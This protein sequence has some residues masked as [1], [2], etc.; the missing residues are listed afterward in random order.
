MHF[1]SMMVMYEG[2]I[3]N[4]RCGFGLFFLGGVKKSNKVLSAI[5]PLLSAAC[6]LIQRHEDT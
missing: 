5:C 6:C 2:V 3:W 1:N 4:F